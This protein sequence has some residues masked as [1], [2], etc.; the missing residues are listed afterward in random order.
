MDSAKV[1]PSELFASPVQLQVPHFQRAYVWNKDIHWEPLWLDVQDT[2]D[3]FLH[4]LE[5]TA[6]QLHASDL[7]PPHF[8]GT[9]VLKQLP[10]LPGHPQQRLIVDGQQ[11]LTTLQLILASVQ[12]VLKRLEDSRRETSLVA[13]GD[14]LAALD[15]YLIN[16]LPAGA[17]AQ[18]QFKIR[19]IG[20]DVKTFTELVG[21]GSSED[22]DSPL[23]R[24][25]DYFHH[26][27]T[28]YL[29]AGDTALEE[30]RARALVTSVTDLF[31]LFSL[32]LSSQENEY[33]IYETLNARGEPLTE[34][35]KA[36]NH[37]L[38]QYAERRSA[39]TTPT[40]DFY[41][42]Y[43]SVFDSDVWWREDATQPRF[44]GDRVSLLLNHWLKIQLR[45]HI[46]HFRSYHHLT[47]HI[48]KCGNTEH[49]REKAASVRHFAHI[50][51][52]LE[53]TPEDDSAQGRFRYRRR[54]M[55]ATAV[56]PVM[57]QLTDLL[58][59]S[60]E[61]NQCTAALESFLI[62]RQIVGYYARGYDDLFLNVLRR[63][64]ESA[65]DQVSVSAIRVI[66]D[67]LE[68]SRFEWP[69]DATVRDAVIRNPVR[70]AD[71]RLRMLLEAV[72]S[73]LTPQMAGRQTVPS[74][75]WIE[76]V[77]PRKWEDEWPLEDTSDDAENQRNRL[78]ETFGNLTLTSSKMNIAVSNRKWTR[79]KETLRTDNLFLN[80]RLLDELGDRPWDEEAIQKRSGA[81][82][83]AMCR[84]WPDGET[85]RR[86][87]DI[88]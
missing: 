66:M 48:K 7:T 1:K 10:T 17:D 79:K 71:T 25:F 24:C 5:R 65:D 33:L 74:K 46:P 80:R 83:D 61:L 29:C 9:I 68:K 26:Q 4:S 32:N 62:R 16:R 52:Q 8:F 56:V 64:I 45:E 50:F 22:S 58:G 70:M 86:V 76:H 14:L 12:V 38:S 44:T 21:S 27:A 28:N 31:L 69:D 11:R 43:F 51:R 78:I 42:Q 20:A 49:I 3:R 19:H 40:E 6:D 75:L 18:E 57:M 88:D 37:F 81:L 82:A 53:T 87:F 2:A 30:R 36:K 34:W 39:T 41:A 72:E 77:M 60:D 55:T 47:R 73:H 63:L 59:I 67:S 35:N 13:H 54:I 23:S 85:L 15:S 84:I